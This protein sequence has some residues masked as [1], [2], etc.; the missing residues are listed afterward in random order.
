[1]TEDRLDPRL[2]AYRPD[3]ADARL[4]GKVE[5]T[6]FVEGTLTRVVA[7]V[8]AAEAR[9]ARRRLRSTPSCSAARSSRVFDDTGEGWSWVQIADRRLCRLSSRPMRSGRS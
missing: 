3:L 5:A 8:G 6:R 2:N 4:R 7:A 9:A 1:M